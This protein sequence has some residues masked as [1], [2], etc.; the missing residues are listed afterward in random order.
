MILVHSH[1]V[2]NL[3]I[4]LFILNIDESWV[5][6]SDYRFMKWVDYRRP[7]S[8]AKKSVTPRISLIAA[9]DNLGNMYACMTQVNTDGK[10]MCMYLRELT[11][12]LDKE[13]KGWRNNTVMLFDGAAYHLGSETM[14]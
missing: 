1:G 2:Q 8:V 4:N 6:L 5:D 9:I 14:T 12:V 10:I 11:K 13:R 3:R 7:A